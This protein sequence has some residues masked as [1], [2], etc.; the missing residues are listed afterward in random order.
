MNGLGLV[1]I[2]VAYGLVGKLTA[3]STQRECMGMLQCCTSKFEVLVV[4]A[5]A[6]GEERGVGGGVG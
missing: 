1:A 5:A 6:L 2:G 3:T 4:W